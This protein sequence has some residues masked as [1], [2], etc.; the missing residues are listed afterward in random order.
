MQNQ[1]IEYKEESPLAEE[2]RQL[3][4]RLYGTVEGKEKFEIESATS[5]FYF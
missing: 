3:F 5:R 1:N 4:R 2:G